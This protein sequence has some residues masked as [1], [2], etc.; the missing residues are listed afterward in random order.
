MV[1]NTSYDDIIPI[2]SEGKCNIIIVGQR[3][4]P[5]FTDNMS[6]MSKA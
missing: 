6:E 4:A 1:H 3:T 2:R 5:C